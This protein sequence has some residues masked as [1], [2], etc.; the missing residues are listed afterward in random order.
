[1]SNVLVNALLA[2][3]ERLDA[4]VRRMIAR[5]GADAVKE[6]VKRLAKGKIGRKPEK[7]WPE[8]SKDMHEDARSWLDG[9]D[10]FTERSSYSIAQGFA[11]R[12]PGHSRA[13]TQRRIL[14]K[15]SGERVFR[16]LTLALH[17]AEREYPHA[18]YLRTLG[19][20][21]RTSSNPEICVS[22]LRFAEETL[23]SYTGMFGSP[24]DNLPMHA[25]RSALN[26]VGM[27][28][29]LSTAVVKTRPQGI[30]GPLSLGKG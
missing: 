17:I 11:G 16:A 20:L 5:Y 10:P 19:E 26:P 13:A 21:I 3:S 14:K 8:L 24:P 6:S 27:S 28:A 22:L 7:D 25:I 9:G 12:F 2:S 4:E 15:L 18:A 29:S 23:V 30:L 1:M